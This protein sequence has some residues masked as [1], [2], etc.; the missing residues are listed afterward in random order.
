MK[1]GDIKQ[2]S[3]TETYKEVNVARMSSL[4]KT[5]TQDYLQPLWEKYMRE[6]TGINVQVTVVFD[7]YSFGNGLKHWDLLINVKANEEYDSKADIEYIWEKWDSQN[8]TDHRSRQDDQITKFSVLWTLSCTSSIKNATPK[9][10]M[11]CRMQTRMV[12]FPN[13]STTSLETAQT[14]VSNVIVNGGDA[15][16]K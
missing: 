7:E 4:R 12:L 6:F 3:E 15:P 5:K 10:W 14:Q 11:V 8:Q 1:R 9:K 13:L 2:L 16:S